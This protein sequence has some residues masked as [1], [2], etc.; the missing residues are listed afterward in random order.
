[1]A[2]TFEVDGHEL[3]VGEEIVERAKAEHEFANALRVVVRATNEFEPA[4]RSATRSVAF[5]KMANMDCEQLAWVKKLEDVVNPA[6]IL[7]AFP[8]G[9][10]KPPLAF[11]DTPQN[12]EMLAEIQAKAKQE[13]PSA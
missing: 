9:K 2:G 5:A 10:D 6:R 8:Y 4:K 7:I 1:M 3:W 11:E 12:R 13:P